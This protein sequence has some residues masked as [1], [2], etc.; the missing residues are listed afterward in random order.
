MGNL[1]TNQAITQKTS[2]PAAL[3][4]YVVPTNNLT[5]PRHSLVYPFAALR[6]PPISYPAHFR[7]TLFMLMPEPPSGVFRSAFHQGV[8]G[9]QSHFH[10]RP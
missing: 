5:A 7:H 3:L 9:E 1:L 4:G 6:Q 8:L 10:A 2:H